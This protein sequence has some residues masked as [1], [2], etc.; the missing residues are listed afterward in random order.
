MESAVESITLNM[1][2]SILKNEQQTATLQTKIQDINTTSEIIEKVK[3]I[4][5]PT[6]NQIRALVAESQKKV[7]AKIKRL[8][9]DEMI[10]EDYFGPNDEC[11]H[12]KDYIVSMIFKARHESLEGIKSIQTTIVKQK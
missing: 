11:K 10:K 8:Y 12:M 4:L 9:E 3:E 6:H 1:N 7:E 5:E 2:M